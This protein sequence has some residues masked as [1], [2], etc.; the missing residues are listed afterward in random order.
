[1]KEASDWRK[2]FSFFNF[3]SIPLCCWVSPLHV[4]YRNDFWKFFLCQD[5]SMPLDFFVSIKAALRENCLNS[6]ITTS[7]HDFFWPKGK[8]LYLIPLPLPFPFCIFEGDFS[9]SWPSFL[10]NRN[11][12]NSVMVNI[13]STVFSSATKRLNFRSNCFFGEICWKIKAWNLRFWQSSFWCSKGLFIF[14]MISFAVVPKH[15]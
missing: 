4:V 13:L 11:I 1:M 3:W 10:L 15:E 12:M 8:I 5:F 7:F 2:I 14:S 9:I 6:C